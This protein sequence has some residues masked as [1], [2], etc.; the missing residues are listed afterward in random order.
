MKLCLLL[1]GVYNVAW[2]VLAGWFPDVPFH[3]AGMEPVN[4]PELWQC[5]GMVIGV[6]GFGYMIA[7]SNPYRHWPIVFVGLM[8]KVLG[9]IGFFIAVMKE[10]FHL[11]FGVMILTNDLIW[12]IPFGLILW[13][14][15]QHR[16][17]P[18]PARSGSRR[19][20]SHSSVLD[21][22]RSR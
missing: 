12:W 22:A 15:W 5:L 10:R 2:G 9:P 1:A 4:Y 6:Y 11:E 3:W 7:A 13:G 17:K 16:S 14:A 18:S 21:P 8:G 20:P 19:A